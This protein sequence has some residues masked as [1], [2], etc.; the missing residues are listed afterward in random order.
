MTP[1]SPRPVR[2][3]VAAIALGTLACSG[4]TEPPRVPVATVTVN[5]S[6]A[7]LMVGAKASLSATPLDAAG[8]ALSGR[9]VQ[10]SSTNPAVASVTQ[11]GE[12]TGLAPG[13]PVSITAT[14]EGKGATSSVMVLPPVASVRMTPASVSVIEGSTSQLTAAPLDGAGNVLTDRTVT[15]LSSNPAIA[16]VSASGLVSAVAVGGPVSITATAEGKSTSAAITVIARNPCSLAQTRFIRVGT[17]VSDSLTRADCLQTT[18]HWS[19]GWRLVLDGS[20]TVQIDLTSAYDNRLILAA[21][22]GGV[23][24]IPIASDDDGG[25]ESNA[26]ISRTLAAG[27]YLILATTYATSVTGPYQLSVQGMAA[28]R[29]ASG[30][31]PVAASSVSSTSSSSAVSLQ[32]LTQATGPSPAKY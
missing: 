15:W 22:I 11:S 10:W 8:Q 14:S 9:S 18:G 30:M 32:A 16:S 27:T 24:L 13:G 28:S 19:E 7:T 29:V 12:V 23:F 20:T 4:T 6:A 21:V 3:L 26:R 5:P 25:P 1:N 31:Q 17:T 2:L